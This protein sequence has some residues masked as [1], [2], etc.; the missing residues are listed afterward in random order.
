MR[1]PRE[2]GRRERL[3]PRGGEPKH[4]CVNRRAL[5]IDLEGGSQSTECALAAGRGGTAALVGVEGALQPGPSRKAVSA[6]AAQQAVWSAPS[7][8]WLARCKVEHA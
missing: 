8:G 4:G 5:R 2:A 7:T 6:T 1:L 3:P